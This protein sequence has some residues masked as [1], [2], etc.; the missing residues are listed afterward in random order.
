[1]LLVFLLCTGKQHLNILVHVATVT[2]SPTYTESFEVT[3]E[4]QYLT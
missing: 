4:H 2:L 3:S 1:M